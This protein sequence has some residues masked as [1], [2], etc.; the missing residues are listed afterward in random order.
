MSDKQREAW[1]TWAGAAADAAN[2]SINFGRGLVPKE[3]T[4]LLPDQLFSVPQPESTVDKAVRFA[5]PFV[6]PGPKAGRVEK[7]NALRALNR[8]ELEEAFEELRNQKAIHDKLDQA[9]E[10][11][12]DLKNVEYLLGLARRKG[13][14]RNVPADRPKNVRDSFR[15]WLYKGSFAEDSVK[16]GREAKAD[17]RKEEFDA[18]I[19]AT[20]NNGGPLAG[21]YDELEQAMYERLFG[22]KIEYWQGKVYRDKDDLMSPITPY[23]GKYPWYDE[24]FR[25]KK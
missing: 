4:Q 1:R 9:F 23:R 19:A 5:V 12:E 10:R 11:L 24:R 8:D 2:D 15:E 20:R 3:Y 16:R 22:P 25:G 13:D 21:S 14:I 6:M 18:D 17:I 7:L